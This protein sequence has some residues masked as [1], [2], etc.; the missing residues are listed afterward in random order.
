MQAMEDGYVVDVV[1]VFVGDGQVDGALPFCEV[2]SV[3][4]HFTY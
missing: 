4:L 2:V 1:I 3:A